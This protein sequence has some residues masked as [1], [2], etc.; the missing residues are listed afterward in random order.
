[1][2]FH[3]LDNS[4][5][6][7]DKFTYPFCYKP[8]AVCITAA[9]QLIAHI[10]GDERL[11][12]A[13]KQGK[14]FGVLVV[15]DN[16]GQLG[17]LA[18]YSGT[19]NFDFDNSYFVPPVFDYLQEDGFFKIGEREITAINHRIDEAEKNPELERLKKQTETLRTTA[20]EEIEAYR[21]LI[22]E[23]KTLRHQRRN[24][25][26]TAEEEEQMQNESRFMKAELKRLK[27]RKEKEITEASQKLEE[28][29]AGIE[30]LRQLR[31]EKSDALQEK[32]FRHF[33]MLDKDGNTKDVCDIFKE[34]S[35]GVPPSGT[36]ECCAPKMIQYAFSEGY[37]LVAMAEFWY[38]M[39]PAAEIRR[40]LHYYP[41][42]MGKCKPLLT[43]MLHGIEMDANPMEHEVEESLDIAYEDDNICIIDKPSG[44]PTVDGKINTLSA[45]HIL[46]TMRASDDIK[47]V[48]R[49]D[50]DTSG[51]VVFAKDENTY[52]EMQRL[53]AGR[54]VKKRYTAVLDGEITTKNGRIS[55]PLSPDYI[56]RPM[57]M[58]DMKNGKEAITSY[59][60]MSVHD[61]RTLVSLIP[62][63]G[64]T[65]QL[66]V[67]CACSEGLN[68]PIVGDN[69]Y[70]RPAERL[71]LHASYVEFIHPLTGQ[72]ISVKSEPP[73]H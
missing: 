49:L 31:K 11:L 45:E 68:T 10:E 40:H 19:T 26:C 63:T 67:H 6:L 27:N 53:F 23:A 59:R 56:N 8:H 22:D 36:G 14:M 1:M 52:V 30:A 25:G 65:H 37:T 33:L 48:H 32:L 58:V 39:T 24:A 3:P 13:A 64:R 50:M 66:R 4:I 72:R 2:K 42:C 47:A 43:Y 21:R 20:S 62:I 35:A 16:D 61:G 29:N 73:F 17:F 46:Q 15:K 71:L 69:L 51:L 70:G 55:L 44:M 41:S 12:S 57:Q 28:M 34:Q 38:G 9:G 54:E 60:V 5:T 18:A 7:P